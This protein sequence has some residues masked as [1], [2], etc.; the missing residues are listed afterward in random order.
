M[1]D[2]AKARAPHRAPLLGANGHGAGD[3]PGGRTRELIQRVQAGD[4]EAW[5]RLHERYRRVLTWLHRGRIPSRLRGRM[6]TEDLVSSTLVAVV[7]EIGGF[8]DRGPGSFHAWVTRILENKLNGAVRAQQ[9]AKRD[10]RR[11]Q[12]LTEGERRP[13]DAPGGSPSEQ[14]A[15]AEQ[16]AR[17]L[18]HIAELP[19]PGRSLIERCHLEGVPMTRAAAELQLPETTA[20]RLHER[21]FRELVRRAH[22]GDADGA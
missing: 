15:D 7:R 5:D 14:V 11:E 3:D 16:L 19:E 18:Q 10:A 6:D 22:E 2:P 8:R 21:C 12:P 1:D 13:P 20:R 17:L 9:A 4:R